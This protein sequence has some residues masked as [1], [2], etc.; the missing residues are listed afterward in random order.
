MPKSTG[1]ALVLKVHLSFSVS[2]CLGL[3]LVPLFWCSRDWPCLCHRGISFLSVAVPSICHL[4]E[5]N[6]V[7]QRQVAITKEY[8]K[9]KRNISSGLNPQQ[10]LCSCQKAISTFL[11]SLC[12]FHS[13]QPG[14]TSKGQVILSSWMSTSNFMLSVKQVPLISLRAKSDFSPSASSSR[15]D[16]CCRVKDRSVLDSRSLPTPGSLQTVHVLYFL[17]WHWNSVRLNRLG[18]TNTCITHIS[19]QDCPTRCFLEACFYKAKQIAI[20]KI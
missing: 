20:L 14:M 2:W 13:P 6:L 3:L 17:P 11:S 15:S 4:L 1:S 10:V 9:S 19:G 12:L 18:H 16:T 8:S 7:L 5:G